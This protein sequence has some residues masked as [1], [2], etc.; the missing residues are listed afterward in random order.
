[1]HANKRINNACFS[2]LP[3]PIGLPPVQLVMKDILTG[4]Q[5]LAKLRPAETMEVV[6]LEE[7]TFN[8][9]YREDDILMM[10]VWLRCLLAAFEGL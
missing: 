10:M 9:L 1:M 2:D 4:S 8:F 3:I 7:K 5:E 6:R